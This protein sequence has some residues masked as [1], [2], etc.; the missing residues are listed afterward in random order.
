MYSRYNASPKQIK[1]LDLLLNGANDD[2]FMEI[3]L[4][5]RSMLFALC[6]Y[7]KVLRLNGRGYISFME[8]EKHYDNKDIQLLHKCVNEM[9]LE[10]YPICEIVNFYNLML[11]TGTSLEDVYVNHMER[12]NDVL[13]SLLNL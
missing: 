5:S 9:C 6:T 7:R 3:Y 8:L 11:Q 1:W 12:P 10:Y 4:N 13:L 2:E